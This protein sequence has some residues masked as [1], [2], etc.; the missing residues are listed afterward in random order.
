MSLADYHFVGTPVEESGTAVDCTRDVNGDGLSDIMVSA[1]GSDAVATN[2]GRI[3]V[4]S[5][6]GL[7]ASGTLSAAQ[8][9]YIFER[10][11]ENSQAGEKASF[12][13]D[14]NGDGFNDIML[15]VPDRYDG[16]EKRGGIHIITSP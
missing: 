1:Y 13:G 12:A 5:G 11:M 2:S 14:I 7:T 6:A 9:D 4:F 16:T 8:A 15:T 10:E 3:Y